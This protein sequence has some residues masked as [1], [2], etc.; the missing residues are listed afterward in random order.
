MDGMS[1]LR[2]RSVVAALA[3]LLALSPA[4]LAAAPH[5]TAP[6]ARAATAAYRSPAQWLAYLNSLTSRSDKRV[7]TGQHLPE[8]ES[9]ADG[10]TDYARG[11][12]ILGTVALTGADDSY[13]FQAGLA[14]RMAQQLNA[15][16]LVLMD[17][18]PANP[19]AR[20]GSRT[21][22]SAWV[23]NA[24]AAKPSLPA[25]YASAP[26]SSARTA[27]WA[28]VDRLVAFLNRLPVGATIAFR[29]FHE[30]NGSY[31]WWGMDRT[32]PNATRSA[33]LVQ[34]TTD[35][36]DYVTAHVTTVKILWMHDCNAL[37]WDSACSFGRPSWVDLVGADLY[38]NTLTMPNK[39]SD[40]YADLVATG[41][42]ILFGEVGPDDTTPNGGTWDST[43]IIN[44]IRST[45]P[46]VVG[47]QGWHETNG[48]MLNPVENQNSAQ[49]F[50]DPWSVQLADIP[51]VTTPGCGG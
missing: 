4:V 13:A 41:K 31:F 34:L 27:W 39:Y 50:A 16:G 20:A 32:V 24:S 40:T 30:S 3:T 22:S 21:I 23:S 46:K 33:Q 1:I 35:L 6:A 19:T 43:T 49:L 47:W 10:T 18:H 45:F 26:A 51:P 9:A 37:D 29:P 11:Q 36:R 15:G 48:A 28:E 5:S 17:M 25:L 44:R 14:D 38:S 2:T 7:L 8:W 12:A 42:P